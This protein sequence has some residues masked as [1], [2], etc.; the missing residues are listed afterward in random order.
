MLR[1]ALGVALVSGL[2][3]APVAFAQ[4]REVEPGAT[5]ID[6]TFQ[7]WQLEDPTEVKAV[8]ARLYKAVQYVCQTDGGDGPLWRVADDRACED[9]AMRG[10]L[11]QL[12]RPEL[13][14]LYVPGAPQLAVIDTGRPAR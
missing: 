9:D 5:R 12:K 8:Y 3:A 2:V 14:A 6:I 10:A 11:Q 1:I 4:G 13:N 7:T